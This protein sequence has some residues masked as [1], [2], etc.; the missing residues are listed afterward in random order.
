MKN[1]ERPQIEN[2]AFSKKDRR[3]FGFDLAWWNTAVLVSLAL[4]AMAAV[5]VLVATRAVIMLQNQE[6]KDNSDALERYKLEV[7][8]KVAES[9]ERAANL[10]KEAA[11]ARLEQEKLKA[12]L[13]WQTMS[14]QA[15]ETLTRRLSTKPGSV[16]VQYVAND[17]EA[18]AFAIQI[19]NVFDS[20]GWTVALMGQTY[21]GAVF[22][23]LWV[24]GPQTDETKLIREAITESGD[25]FSIDE[26]PPAAMGVGDSI[27][28][29]PIL[30][31]GTKPPP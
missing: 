4:A 26:L 21:A 12:Q 9:N 31:V 22:C 14:R 15:A 24:P 8:A 25:S 16:N 11:D 30:F 23:G 29:A 20:A 3:M 28:D 10:E 6:A 7:T 17:P 1:I 13:A 19:A 2:A 5:A 27:P 18:H